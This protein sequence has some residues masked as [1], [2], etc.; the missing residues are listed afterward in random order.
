MMSMSVSTD[1]DQPT[2]DGGREDEEEREVN[3]ELR[4]QH[5]R[6]LRCRLKVA[7]AIMV[8]CLF[9]AFMLLWRAEDGSTG[10]FHQ[11]FWLGNKGKGDSGLNAEGFH[12]GKIDD[13]D[14][15]D[16][17]SDDDDFETHMMEVALPKK[18]PLPTRWPTH[19]PTTFSPTPKPMPIP[20][21]NICTPPI[22][23]STDDGAVFTI[24]DHINFVH[25]D[26]PCQYNCN[27]EI[28]ALTIGGRGELVTAGFPFFTRPKTSASVGENA[29]MWVG[30]VRTFAYSCDHGAYRQIG[31]D[32][33]PED[34]EAIGDL[35]G[36][37]VEAT[38]NGK[39]LAIGAKVDNDV[40]RMRPNLKPYVEIYHLVDDRN[41]QRWER[42]GERILGWVA[43]AKESDAKAMSG[44]AF[45]EDGSAVALFDQDSRYYC[46][47]E[48]AN[49]RINVFQ[50]DIS[51][52]EG[53]GHGRRNQR[54]TKSRGMST[55]W[56]M[57]GEPIPVPSA[58]SY[59]LIELAGNNT[60]SSQLILS[61]KHPYLGTERYGFDSEV[62]QWENI[63][64]QPQFQIA[65]Y[66][67][68]AL[69]LGT[70]SLVGGSGPGGG[71]MAFTAEAGEPDTPNRRGG[72]QHA[73]V[74][75]DLSAKAKDMIVYSESY[76]DWQVKTDA[77]VSRC[78][79]VV[80]VLPSIGSIRNGDLE[81][82]TQWPASK[83]I[84][85]V[86]VFVQKNASKRGE[87]AGDAE[88]RLLEEPMA[89]QFA[90][91]WSKGVDSNNTRWF[92]L[93]E[94]LKV[95]GHL[96]ERHK[97]YVWLS[98]DGMIA[99]VGNTFSVSLYQIRVPS[100]IPGVKEDS[101]T[102]KLDE[103]ISYESS[104]KSNELN[105]N[106]LMA[107]DICPP[108]PNATDAM[109][110]GDL[111][112]DV[113]GINRHSL[114]IASSYD[115]SIVAV[116]MPGADS[117]G[118]V[119]VYAWSCHHLK[120]VSFG[121]DLHGG[122][123]F[124]GFG[125]SVDISS[126]GMFLCV[127]AN[128][129]LPGR[130]GYVEV[131][132]Y[133]TG[134][135]KWELAGQRI[136]VASQNGYRAAVGRNVKISN[137]GSIVAFSGTT[138]P[139]G[140][141]SYFIGVFTLRNGNWE[142]IWNENSLIKSGGLRDGE[143]VHLSLSG[144]GTTLAVVSGSTSYEMWDSFARVYDIDLSMNSWSEYIIPKSHE[145]KEFHGY[146]VVVNEE[147]TEIAIAGTTNGS[148]CHGILIRF[149]EK[150]VTG[151]WTLK[152]DGIAPK[153][154]QEAYSIG[155]VSGFDAKGTAFALGVNS[156]TEEEPSSGSGWAR[157]ALYLASI[158]DKAGDMSWDSFNMV[159]GEEDLDQLGSTLC[160]S[161]DGAFTIA[162]SRAGY[163]RFFRMVSLE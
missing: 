124:D 28:S 5:E 34:P 29:G 80:A 38:P 118:M 10:I 119:R 136:N 148:T 25:D 112:L 62:E 96:D 2:D 23:T 133:N 68:S 139:Y 74:I 152:S 140:E 27:G 19:S 116:G 69:Y 111:I 115:A 85:E 123:K 106:Q 153:D 72:A 138:T 47:D 93:E 73:A 57:L 101:A 127:G 155:A 42:R 66:L 89:Q 134:H 135:W 40:A 86:K 49:C 150:T 105:P 83:R 21:V 63:D 99:A 94:S 162:G 53:D 6:S 146:G 128:Q 20:Y 50:Y 60:G 109:H 56:S 108:F 90:E 13:D 48:G 113:P 52:E 26:V 7:L 125:M 102:A 43:P 41:V 100:D 70:E 137:D 129:P 24:L 71:I 67:D 51:G 160:I 131:Y 103:P 157:G 14:C 65:P 64:E 98:N 130:S 132:R 78:G 121:Q 95:S 1:E 163:L 46:R 87:T 149:A 75:T 145:Y 158:G 22:P 44:L 142:Q 17:C 107:S 54:R 143:K 141:V 151:E 32:L 3:L 9:A 104:E 84:G 58:G 11:L 156:Y 15:D 81:S 4:P 59:P 110:A 33:S 77:A 61:F 91:K 120:F 154:G 122:S 39:V 31:P 88:G 18:H 45:N 76:I 36:A 8:G 117:K 82:W 126:D 55:S 97:L 37:A 92:A 147:G 16:D 114:S 159:K 30:V 79:N 12:P 35:F 161:Q 144:D